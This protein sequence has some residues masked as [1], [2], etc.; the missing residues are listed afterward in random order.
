[1]EMRFAVDVPSQLGKE[2]RIMPV[3]AGQRHKLPDFAPVGHVEIRMQVS[4]YN[5]TLFVFCNDV[6]DSS[7]NGEPIRWARAL[8]AAY[9]EHLVTQSPLGRRAMI[10]VWLLDSSGER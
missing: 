8:A 3:K 2:C 5:R 1:M 4:E 6:S 7:L 9:W 10:T